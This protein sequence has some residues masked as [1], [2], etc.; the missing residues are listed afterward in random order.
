MHLDHYDRITLNT[1]VLD[2]GRIEVLAPKI[3][4]WS[5]Q[6]EEYALLRSGATVG[7]LRCRTRRFVLILPADAEGQVVAMP[8]ADRIAA[9]EYGETMFVLDHMGTIQDR[10]VAVQE[11]SED[12]TT[13]DR[14]ADGVTAVR[15]TTDGVFYLRP[16]P[17]DP[18]FV[19]AGSTIRTG[20]TIGLVEVMKTFNPILYGAPDLPEEA[21]VVEVRVGD[22]AEIRAGEIL[23]TVRSM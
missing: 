18:P 4:F 9:V 10:N 8:H 3:G 7:T 22:G 12:G 1:R 6:P 19:E 15:A 13:G 2:D 20:R 23:I 11:T 16:A 17:G 14:L 5:G 21:E